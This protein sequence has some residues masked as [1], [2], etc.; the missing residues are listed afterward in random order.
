MA[1]RACPNRTPGSYLLFAR[2]DMETTV[3]YTDLEASSEAGQELGLKVRTGLGRTPDAV[4]M[5]ASPKYDH[6][7]L[8]SSFADECPCEVVVG[9][10]SAGEFTREV[11]GRGMACAL[12]FYAPDIRFSA[13]VGQ[14]LSRNPKSAAR[15]IVAGFDERSDRKHSFRSAL[16]MTDAMAGHADV[17]VEELTLATA[18][19]YQF[20]GGGAGDDA[21]FSRTPVFFGTQVLTDAAVALEI[22]SD[23]PV[24]IGVSHGWEPCAEAFRV[25]EA[26]GMRVISLNGFPAVEAF[27]E[28][29][30]LTEQKIDRDAPIPFF[31]HNILGIEVGGAYRLRVPLAINEDGSVLCASEVPVGSVVR[32][33]RSSEVSAITAAERA[34]DAALRALGEHKPQAALFFDCVATRLRLGDRFG[35]EVAAVTEKLGGIDL[36]GCN[37]HGQIARADGQFEGFHNCTA[38]VCVFPE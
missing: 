14:D 9:A 34:S 35:S 26:N 29:A 16:V 10:S 25:T 4:V 17:L 18:G 1:Y 6:S 24:G 8:L 20:V 2:A 30:E 3:A 21:Q 22:L 15:Q 11:R 5:F 36:A 32:I 13:C 27:Q 31:L 12:A 37:T 23:K 33:M 38:V 19:Q 28:H 7:A